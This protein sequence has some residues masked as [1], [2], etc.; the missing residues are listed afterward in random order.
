MSLTF[1][2]KDPQSDDK[3][4]PSVWVDDEAREFVFQ[5][6]DALEELLAT[7]RA[8]GPVPDG[9]SV[10]RL[11]FKMADQIRKAC[12]AAAAHGYD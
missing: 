2:G 12:D 10:V 5:G 1:F 6:W 3:D 11:P 7:C 9:E 8:Q 4:C